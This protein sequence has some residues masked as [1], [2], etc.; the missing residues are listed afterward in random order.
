MWRSIKW[1][2]LQKTFE[3]FFH[4][5]ILQYS[6][7]TSKLINFWFFLAKNEKLSF[8]SKT[9]LIFCKGHFCVFIL[10]NVRFE[11]KN[12][13]KWKLWINTTILDIR[14]KRWSNLSFKFTNFSFFWQ[15]KN[16]LRFFYF[17]PKPSKIAQL[18]GQFYVL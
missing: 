8:L 5:T 3:N 2:D 9:F 13:G 15:K 6:K 7:F 14:F 18:Q 17:L 1:L 4:T 12:D 11:H 16:E 10:L